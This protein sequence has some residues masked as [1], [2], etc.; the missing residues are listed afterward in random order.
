MNGADHNHDGHWLGAKSGWKARAGAVG[1]ALGYLLIAFGGVLAGSAALRAITGRTLAELLAAGGASALLGHGALLLTLGIAPT[2]AMIM[3]GRAPLRESGWCSPRW[4]SQ[5]GLGALL[6]AGLISLVAGALYAA[7]MLHIQPGAFDANAAGAM[8][9]TWALI[10]LV[11]AAH[12]EMLFRGYAMIQVSASIG[13]WPA[14]LL[15]SLVFAAAHAGNAGENPLG[16][17]N[18]ALIGLALAYSLKRT[19]ALWLAWGFHAAWNFFQTSIWG[20]SNSGAEAPS[21]VLRSALSGPAWLTGA[22]V[23]PEG[24]VL[25]TGAAALLL[26]AVLIAPN[27]TRAP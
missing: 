9:A 14:A 16:L 3:F 20:F 23:G 12:E 8:L 13:F 7:G 5:F 11:Q 24:S 17:A 6:G 18:A 4:A 1:Y 10:W 21:S 25:S 22:S 26:A 2:A 27:K 19:G 15:S